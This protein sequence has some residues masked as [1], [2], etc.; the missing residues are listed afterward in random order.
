MMNN[1]FAPDSSQT[2]DKRSMTSERSEKHDTPMRNQPRVKIW[3]VTL[4]QPKPKDKIIHYLVTPEKPLDVKKVAE[5][6]AELYD[7]D[8]YLYGNFF[9]FFEVYL[10][11]AVEFRRIEQVTLQV[12]GEFDA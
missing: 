3:T 7:M 2:K 4:F 8:V 12:L 9:N 6:M 5:R 10:E 1:R 11:R